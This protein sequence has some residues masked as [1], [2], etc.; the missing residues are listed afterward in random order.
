M[1]FAV[2]CEKDKMYCTSDIPK[3]KRSEVEKLNVYVKAN[4]KPVDDSYQGETY[5]IEGKK[6]PIGKIREAPEKGFPEG[7]RRR[8]FTSTFHIDD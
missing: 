8:C 7:I 4:I 2:S 3:Y 1:F 6:Y 5:D